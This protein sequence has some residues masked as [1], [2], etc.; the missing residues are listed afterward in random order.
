MLRRSHGVL[1]SAWAAGLSGPGRL[2]GL[3]VNLVGAS[4]GEVKSGGRDLGIRYGVADSPFGPCL[5]A[6]TP[7]GLCGLGFPGSDGVT[8]ELERLRGD[9]PNARWRADREL[10]R[11]LARRIFAT[12]GSGRGEL[13]LHVRGTNFQLRLWEA[14]LRIPPATVTSYSALGQL[15]ERPAAARSV[16]HAVAC[17]RVGYLIPCHRVIRESGV[18]GEYRWGRGRKRALLAW[19]A[20]QCGD[21]A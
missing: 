19:E 7:R 2:H 15:L 21:D 16:G 20:L 1:E 10:A 8:S 13:T 18:L 4:P 11:E 12:D 5:L 3:T 9:W 6:A 17:N 14:L